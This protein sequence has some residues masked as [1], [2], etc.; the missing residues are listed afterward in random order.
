MNMEGFQEAM[1]QLGGV[2][3]TLT[4]VMSWLNSNIFSK[5]GSVVDFFEKVIGFIT[6]LFA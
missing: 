2:M 5:T 3:E 4:K 1:E 6:N